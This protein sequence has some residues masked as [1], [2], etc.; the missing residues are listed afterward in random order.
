MEME[1]QAPPPLTIPPPAAAGLPLTPQSSNKG[2]P[3]IPFG[4]TTYPHQSH[5]LQHHT[6][7]NT[8]MSSSNNMEMEMD[9]SA[10]ETSNN[11][12]DMSTESRL[13][14][15]REGEEDYHRHQMDLMRGLMEEASAVAAGAAPASS[16]IFMSGGR[17]RAS[18]GLG[19]TPT[20]PPVINTNISNDSMDDHRRGLMEP[21][22]AAASAMGEEE[23]LR[24]LAIALPTP[25]SATSPGSSIRKNNRRRLVVS[26]WFESLAFYSLFW[27]DSVFVFFWVLSSL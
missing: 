10:M 12:S 8:Q 2:T 20:P 14:M 5:N 3:V 25:V 1:D 23:Q 7:P 19:Q 21:R 15:N 24:G 11:A 18:R 27:A 26:S 4:P 16:G 6:Q 9:T 22:D 13:L 17:M